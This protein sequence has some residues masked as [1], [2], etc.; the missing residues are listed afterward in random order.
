M[1]ICSST[2]IIKIY[3]PIQKIEKPN[4]LK[5]FR[6]KKQEAL[7]GITKSQ[8]RLEEFEDTQWTKE[9]GQ[10]DKQRSTRYTHT[11]NDRVTRTPLNNG[12]NSRFSGRVNSSCSTSGT[13]RVNLVTNPVISHES[14]CLRVS[15]TFYLYITVSS[16]DY[17]YG[18]C[19]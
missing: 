13:H 12:V 16:S 7:E 14:G 19:L 9:K 17:V 18:G 6:S 5:F 15:L 2:Q 8:L 3:A 4:N 10:K 1:V 11:T